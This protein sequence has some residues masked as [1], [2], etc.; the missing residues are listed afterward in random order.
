LLEDGIGLHAADGFDVE[1][2]AAGD[3][4]EVKGLA[5]AFLGF[6]IGIATYRPVS[7]LVQDVP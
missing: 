2:E 5:F 6:V 3:G 4:V 7:L 1:V